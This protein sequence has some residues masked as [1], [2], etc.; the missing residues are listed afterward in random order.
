LRDD[1]D[2]PSLEASSSATTFAKAMVVKKASED[3]MADKLKIAATSA[4]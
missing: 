2:P 4:P 3:R 1:G